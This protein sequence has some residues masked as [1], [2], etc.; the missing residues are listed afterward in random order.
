MIQCSEVIGVHYNTFPYIEID[1]E[2]ASAYFE[3]NGLHLHL[4][5]IGSSIEL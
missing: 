1:V 2:K 5:A 4:P 3:K